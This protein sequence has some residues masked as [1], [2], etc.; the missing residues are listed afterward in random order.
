MSTAVIH[1][2]DG[3]LDLEYSAFSCECG[4][5]ECREKMTLRHAEYASLREEGRPIIVAARAQPESRA[6]LAVGE[7]SFAHM[8]PAHSTQGAERSPTP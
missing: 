1:E 3:S 2:L 6:A 8:L 4:D 7:L 5:L